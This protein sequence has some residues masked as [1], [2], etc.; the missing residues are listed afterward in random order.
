[1]YVSVNQLPVYTGLHVTQGLKK[2]ESE[3]FHSQ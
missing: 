1:M 3:A 2:L